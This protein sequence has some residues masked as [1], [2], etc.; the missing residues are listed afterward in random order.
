MGRLL[1]FI[2][3]GVSLPF[4]G[5]VVITGGD[6]GI[7]KEHWLIEKLQGVGNLGDFSNQLAKASRNCL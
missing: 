4:Q 1:T 6:R 7:G 5:R 2:W 3:D